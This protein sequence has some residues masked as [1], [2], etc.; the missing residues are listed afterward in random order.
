MNV[1]FAATLCLMLCLVPCVVVAVRG[2]L[3]DALVALEIASAVA[4]LALLTAEQ[5]MERQ[6]FFDVSLALAVLTL[7]ATLLFLRFYRRWL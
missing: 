3:G 2:K 7:P 5:G 6:T 4:V 1:W